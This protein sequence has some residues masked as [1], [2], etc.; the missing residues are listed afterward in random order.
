M[1]RSLPLLLFIALSAPANAAGALPPSATAK[2]MASA[3]VDDFKKMLRENEATPDEIACV[4]RV[5]GAEVEAAMQNTIDQALTTD[6]RADMERFYASAEGAHLFALYRRWGDTDNPPSASELE[7][8]LPLVKSDI[9]NK[10]FDATSFQSL[11]SAE[12]MR[13][14]LPLL[15]RCSAPG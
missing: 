4:D 11:G 14:I 13:T 8:I 15:T 5:P 9:Q 7:A 12:I 6:E 1:Q 10:L 2:A 3:Y